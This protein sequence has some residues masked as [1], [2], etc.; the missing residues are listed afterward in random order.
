M[1]DPDRFDVV[2]VGSGLAGAILG[3][4]LARRDKRVLIIE[5]GA[6]PKFTIG[7]SMLPQSATLMR[8]I[9]D[10]YD[11]PEISNFSTIREV[12]KHVGTT[13]GVKKCFGF[14]YHREGEPQRPEESH[15]LIQ[16]EVAFADEVHYF[17]QDID[18][19]LL[20]T[21]IKYGC[22][23]R[24]HTQV[25]R[26]TET[27]GGWRV[28]LDGGASV[29]ARYVV[30]CSGHQSVLAQQ[31][32]LR[33]TPTR[34]KTNTRSIFN[35][36]IGVRRYEEF[37]RAPEMMRGLRHN[38]GDGTLHHVF[39]GGWFWVIPFDNHK[40]S[41]NPL[42]SVG[43]TVD[44]NKHPP[45]DLSPEEEFQSFV[46]RF[47]G[48]DVQLGSA[49][50]VQRWV[51][52]PRL[53]YSASRASGRRFF[54]LPHSYG[55]I[56]PLFSRGIISTVESLNSFAWRLLEALD[57]DDF[58]EDRFAYVDA[59]NRRQLDYNDSSVYN[60]YSSFSDFETW[61]A[62]VKVW[63]SGKMYGDLRLFAS[64]ARYLASGDKR[65]FFKLEDDPNPGA[66]CP[67]LPEHQALVERA[68]AV[69]RRFEQK[70][71]DGAAAG[72]EIHAILGG[73]G[74][75]PPAMD[76]ADP[77]ARHVDVN[78]PLLLNIL[79][80]GGTDAPTF[81]KDRVFQFDARRLIPK[82]E[83]APAVLFR[84][85]VNALFAGLDAGIKLKN[86]GRAAS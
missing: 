28:E 27:D 66:I 21:A 72:A 56:D 48:I 75:L 37:F 5:R 55:F 83:A 65:E 67:H 57:D 31:F 63:L 78:P 86:W 35:H 15:M 82:P 81:I 3:A 53:Q 76:W 60:A 71:I 1:S 24:D 42:C 19:R 29:E 30:D 4:V 62:W 46:K 36:M 85:A 13:C 44:A 80:W 12:T 73:A 8:I 77:K 33:E 64:Y 68:A 38:W 7:E 54:L 43:V 14:L 2:I 34:L 20:Q 39:D 16:P 32:G 70:E 74:F 9:G 10:R 51:R 59:L 52:A 11:V 6:H 58:S 47:P 26:F 40:D 18:M 50:A 69:L 22:A 49:R 84:G 41:T 23:Y 79:Y 25:K 61:N 45:Q 17:R